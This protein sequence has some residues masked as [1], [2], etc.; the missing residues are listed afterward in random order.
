MW[1][2][3]NCS[4][5]M[6][7]AFAFKSTTLDTMSITQRPAIKNQ[8]CDQSRGVSCLLTYNK[9]SKLHGRI[10]WKKPKNPDQKIIRDDFISFLH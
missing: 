2:R 6:S 8:C 9:A 10:H 5:C 3:L 4:V 1:L 7:S